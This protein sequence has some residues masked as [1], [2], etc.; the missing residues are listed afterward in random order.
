MSQTIV[1]PLIY[2]PALTGD[3]L[4][5]VGLSGVSS[6]A[7]LI[8][9]SVATVIEQDADA[10]LSFTNATM[11]VLKNG[12]NAVITVVCSNPRVE[13]V[14]VGFFT[15]DG[16]ATNGI[17]YVGTNG[18]L[19]FTNGITTNTFIVP[20]INNNLLE[21]NTTFTVA[22]TNASLFGILTP[23]DVLTVTIIDSN[24]G[25]SFSSPTYS[26]IKTNVQATIMAYRTGFTNS[27]MSVGYATADGS[28]TNGIDYVA[29][30]GVLVFTN[31]VTSQSFLVTLIAK[32][33][34]QPPK[35]VLLAL[36]NP[37]SAVMTY[38]SNAVLTIYDSAPAFNFSAVT[39]TFLETAG[40]VGVNVIRTGNLG[41]SVQVNYATVPGT[42]QPGVN[43]L[44]TSGTLTFTNGE[45]LRAISIQLVDDPAV[46]GDLT[47][48]VGLSN[49]SAG[50]QL[51]YP[52]NTT[53][54]VQDVDVGLSF[55]TNNYSV[56]KNG[57]TEVITVVCSNPN[58][59]PVSVNYATSD[60]TATNGIDYL[61]TSGT[62]TFTNGVTTNTFNVPIINNF[63]ITG[64][65][66]F[67][68]TLSN[69][70]AP[71]QLVSPSVATVTIIDSNSGLSFDSATY[72]IN[73]NGIAAT[74]NVIRTGYTDSV[75]SVNF[76]ATNGTAVAGVNYFSTNGTV[77]FTN[78]V[79]TQSFTVQV[80]NTTV[81]QPDETVLLLLSSP[82]GAQLVPPSAAFLTIHDTSGSY[83]IP[84]GS[85]LV[86]ETGAGVPNG[87]IDPNETVV[88]LF[89]FRDAG[90][91]NV[92][93]LVATLLAT[94][95]VTAVSPASESYGP[96]AYGRHSAFRPF[97]FTA[98]GTNGQQI[99]A[100][101][102]LQDGAKPIGSAVVGYTLGE[103]TSMFSNRAAIYIPAIGSPGG[104]G[105]ASPYPSVINVSGVGGS[106]IKAS[107]TVT[108]LSHQSA[109]DIDMLLVSPNQ[110]SVL[111][112]A[113]AGGVNSIGHVTMKFDDA[114]TNALPQSNTITN[115]W[116]LPTAYLPMPTFP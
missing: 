99:Q 15:A 71:G 76:L 20:I 103:W 91:T 62:L 28:A 70:T 31:G 21:G 111:L 46:T 108:N 115:G 67:N 43:Y 64:N 93:N 45:T 85:A 74:I 84:A 9:P 116:Y 92:G 3:L 83:V 75:V 37:V 2:D 102:Q 32:Q 78:G 81:V 11:S 22:L 30:N 47:F 40:V 24:P 97:Q 51:L 90:G 39:N 29:T 58:F 55:A 96:L 8:A 101:F 77:T 61:G 110:Q 72:A 44:T 88:I 113:H 69:P 14:T 60:G 94:N 25:I 27:V 50:S 6:P 17:D 53:V 80:I 13:P 87:I 54:V 95:G 52:S 1:V 63:L 35:T 49:P 36:T 57:G 41:G 42:A 86:S 106:L 66:T 34:V 19:V 82:I 100:T 114:A 4:F 33:G 26:A 38:P 16:T 59:E 65:R 68:V 112:M 79:T 104:Y 7:E 10:G 89:S 105:I 107:V 18:T 56:L 98:Q 73:K 12:T 109:S 48:G 5:T 23:P